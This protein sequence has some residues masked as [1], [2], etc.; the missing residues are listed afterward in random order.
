MEKSSCREILKAYFNSARMQEELKEKYLD[1]LEQ[2]WDKILESIQG[3]NVYKY[4]FLP[5]EMHF[6]LIVGATD[7]YLLLPPYYCSCHDFYFNAVSKKKEIC[8]YHI[9]TQIISERSNRF[10]TILKQ[11]NMYLDYIEDLLEH[12]RN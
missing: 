7:E 3:D 12:D 9:I 5:S 4:V 8:C 11:D 1:V 6:W 10:K 2:K